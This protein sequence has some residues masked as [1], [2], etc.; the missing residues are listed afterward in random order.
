MLTNDMP[1]PASFASDAERRREYRRRQTHKPPHFSR[2]SNLH[3]ATRLHSTHTTRLWRAAPAQL[4][5]WRPPQ[6]AEHTTRVSC[7]SSPASPALQGGPP[8]PRSPLGGLLGT[9]S[10]SSSSTMSGGRRYPLLHE[11]A[12]ERLAT[13]D[14]PAASPTWTNAISKDGPPTLGDVTT[15]YE[16][17]RC[18][19]R[20]RPAQQT[21]PCL[22]ES[23]LLARAPATQA[24]AAP[25]H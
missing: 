16:S 19:H 6:L 4:V 20:S 13:A 25:A 11:T 8:A 10:S 1:Q 15:L 24:G 9:A 23:R 7:R 2:S 17:F 22:C 21:H 14:R 18:A 12:P 5:S 3:V